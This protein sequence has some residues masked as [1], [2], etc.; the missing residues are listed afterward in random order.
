MNGLAVMDD[1][2]LLN[3]YATRNS[4][5][6][7]RTLVGRYAGMV[8]HT[9]LRQAR[10]T[11]AAEEVTQAVF[12]ALA[13]KAGRIPRQTLL[14][15]WLFRATR[16]A[17][18]NWMRD[19]TC[20]RRHEQEAMNMEISLQF[21][22]PESVWE[23]ISPHLNDALDRLSNTDRE[24]VMSRFFGNKSHKEVAQVLGISEDTAK[25]RLSR[26]LEKL[27]I[28]FTRRGIAV[29]AV[30]LLAAFS[31][32]GAQAA[33]TGLTATVTAA[34]LTKSG[35]GAA[36]TFTLAKATLKLI[37]WAKAKTALAFGAGALLVTA[38]TVTAVFQSGGQQVDDT[39]ANLEHQSGKRIV[40]DK[41]I[42]LPADLDLKNLSL[43][44]ALDQIS[45]KAGAYWTID[46]AVYGSEQSLQQLLGLLREGSGLDSGGWTN[47]SARALQPQISM[48]TS[49]PHGRSRA[50]V[51]MREGHGADQVGMQVVLGPE[52]SAKLAAERNAMAQ[53]GDAGGPDVPGHRP[54]GGNFQVISQAMREGVADGVLAPERL[55]TE[56]SLTSR[57]QVVAPVAANADTAA[58]LAKQAH[59]H[60]T[61]I[62]TLRKSPLDGAG[63]KLVH[64]GMEKMYPPD[65]PP[66]GAVV[67]DAASMIGQMQ[68]QRLTLTPEDRAAHQR[69]VDALKKKGNNPTSQ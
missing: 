21:N 25:K 45:V 2:Q 24:V 63:I 69:A 59:A 4:E 64:T 26:A 51:R 35:A 53:G 19:E 56:T 18:L 32:C 61:T 6:A 20:R 52:A 48:T 36:S 38:G 22:E 65:G 12:I 11:D 46:Y 40:C 16:F 54:F 31:A 23:Q 55:L 10:D 57:M 50:F 8:Y 66:P 49:D 15:G 34:A 62:Y 9:A 47:L 5:E 33:P 67:G 28:F 60:W 17:A 7:F 58:R 68:N 41:R 43:E 37:A 30:A 13:Q 39:L 29:P 27:R 3:D 42:N 44:Q 1:W 14:Y